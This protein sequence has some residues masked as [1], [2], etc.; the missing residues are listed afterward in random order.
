M[1]LQVK[2]TPR[3]QPR[4]RFYRG[5]AVSCA[6][7]GTRAWIGQIELA[8]G[9]ALQEHKQLIGP[10]SISLSFTFGTAQKDR[11]GQAHLATP[12]ADNLA[13]L[14][15]DSFQRAGAFKNDSQVWKLSVSKTWSSIDQA[16]LVADLRQEAPGA[17]Q[18]L[19]WPRW[20]GQ[21]S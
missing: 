12:D 1:I 2:G 5:K 13:K 15:L 16:G 3:P 11:H 8:T 4:P 9:R 7:K 20:L 18:E 19:D 6:D 14:A 17:L 21:P 10:I